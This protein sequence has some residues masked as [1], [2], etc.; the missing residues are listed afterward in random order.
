MMQRYSIAGVLL[1]F[2]LALPLYAQ[3]RDAAGAQFDFVNVNYDARKVALAGASVALPN[4]CYGIFS[5]PAALGYISTMQAVLGYRPLGVG[6]YGVP[7]AYALPKNGIGVF[8]AAVYGLTSGG[9]KS[10][11]KGPDGGALL[12]NDIARVDYIAGN[13]A[14]AKKINEYLSAGV[15]VKGLYTSIKGYEEEG[16][17]VRWSADGF[18]FDGGLQCR[19]MNSRLM[20]GIVVRNIGFL[21]SGFEKDDE[22]LPAAVD[23]GVSYVPRYIEN[24]R[25]IV[26]LSKKWNDYLT[27]KPGAELE[28]LKN[29][30]VVRAGYSFSWRDLRAFKNMLSG[31][32]EMNYFKSN[33]IGLC[34]GVGFFTEIIDRKVQFDA[35]AEFLTI[36][37]LP[38]LVISM[39]V[40]I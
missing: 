37:V 1:S 12:S 16:S 36:P 14:W 26:D 32:E 22:P 27:F 28:L 24:L 11:Y 8:G 38:S 15:T 7:L 9:M 20:Y 19:F 33:M 25:V 29:Q 5:N 17:A 40:N 23:I 39:L 35:A 2:F 4:D 13:V 21:R 31:E 3:H 6:I 30:L 18:A 10:T 34:L